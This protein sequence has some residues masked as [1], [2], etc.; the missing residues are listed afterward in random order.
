M[1][2]RQEASVGRFEK[3]NFSQFNICIFSYYVIN[4]IS[5]VGVGRGEVNKNFISERLSS[6]SP[7]VHTALLAC[8]RKSSSSCYKYTSGSPRQTSLSNASSTAH[9]TFL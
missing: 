6:P 1:Q 8:H 2:K 5:E 7:T 3:L 9:D 4:A